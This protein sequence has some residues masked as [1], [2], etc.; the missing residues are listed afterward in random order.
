MPADEVRWSRLHIRRIMRG[1]VVTEINGLYCSKIKPL[2]GREQKK[3][4]KNYRFTE[5]SKLDKY[6]SLAEDRKEKQIHMAGWRP[7]E[8]KTERSLGRS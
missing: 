7:I 4:D 8:W 5:Y 3:V 1:V 6:D 2:R